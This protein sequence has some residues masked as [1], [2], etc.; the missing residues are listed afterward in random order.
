MGQ[1]VL[2]T[3]GLVELMAPDPRLVAYEGVGAL[4]H[5]R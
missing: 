1:A 3:D 5:D 4:C 2:Q